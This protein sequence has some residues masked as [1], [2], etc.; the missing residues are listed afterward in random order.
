MP[1]RYNVQAALTLLLLLLLLLLQERDSS[2]AKDKFPSAIPMARR[3]KGRIISIF[4]PESVKADT[5]CEVLRF[6]GN[7]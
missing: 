4:S 7:T 5:A 3:G 2:T 6:G 1:S